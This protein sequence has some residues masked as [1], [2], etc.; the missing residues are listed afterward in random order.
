VFTYKGFSLNVLFQYSY[1]N[2]IYNGSRMYIEGLGADD[3]Q[4]TAVLRRWKE[5]GDV[6]DIPRATVKG[7]NNNANLKS[8]RFVEDGSYLRFKSLTLSYD[9]PKEFISLYKLSA[10]K[11]YVSA[12]NLW[13]LTNYSGMDP[14]VNFAGSSNRYIGTDFFTYPQARTITVGISTNF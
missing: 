3:N 7:Y 8:S 5:V 10:T 2:Q 6:T 13:T 1:G 9:L 12:Q 4:T 11:I 14:D